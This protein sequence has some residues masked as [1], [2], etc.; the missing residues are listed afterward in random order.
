LDVISNSNSWEDGM[1]KK[2]LLIFCLIVL[3]CLPISSFG[4]ERNPVIDRIE[5]LK[6][7]YLEGDIEKSLF[8]LS[9]IEGMLKERNVSARKDYSE[10]IPLMEILKEES[11]LMKLS[12]EASIGYKL[13]KYPPKK[14]DDVLRDLNSWLQHKPEN[15]ER[16]G[17]VAEYE[18]TL[19]YQDKLRELFESFGLIGSD[20][21]LFLYSDKEIPIRF[22]GVDGKSCLLVTK[23]T[24]G[25]VY[26][27]IRT[28]AKSRA[29]QVLTSNI[30]PTLSD[31][32]D[33]FKDTDI[34]YYGIVIAYG[35]KNFLDKSVA[36]NL[37][38]EALC[39]VVPKDDCRKF[40]NGEITEKQLLDSS[41]IFISDRDMLSGFKKVEI[42]IE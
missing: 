37:K 39:M 9:E 33:S 21:A 29:A 32:Q 17:Q 3:L 41:Y 11:I 27:T 7:S 12:W 35:S 5:A 6:K 28:T 38:P 15:D 31:F 36:L 23:V 40:V 18:L 14:N 4:Q 20:L 19:K 13:S 24:N 2:L 1:N 42:T 8:I 10:L 34:A 16:K 30:L 22:T 26:N 25:N